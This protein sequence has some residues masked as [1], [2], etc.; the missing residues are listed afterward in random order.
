MDHD[1]THE[2][3]AWQHIR[4]IRRDKG[5]DD[6][7]VPAAIVRDLEAATRVLSDELY[8]KLTRFIM[9]LVQNADDNHYTSGVIPTMQLTY[10]NGFLRMDCNELGFSKANVEAICSI[11]QSSKPKSGAVQYVGEKGIGFKAVFKVADVVWV[12]SGDYSF[13]FDRREPLGMIAPI[14]EKPPGEK[15][16]GW[17]SFYIQLASSQ[18]VKELVA[19]LKILDPRLLL[20]LR[21]LKLIEIAV[22][23]PKPDRPIWK[24]SL[25]RGEKDVSLDGLRAVQLTQDSRPIRYIITRH[26]IHGLKPEPKRPGIFISEAMLA[27]PVDSEQQP[28]TSF[29]HVFAF[30]PIHDYGFNFLIQGDFLLIANREDIDGSSNWNCTIRDQLVDAFVSCVRSFNSK[31]FIRHTWPRYLPQQAKSSGLNFFSPFRSALLDRLSQDDILQNWNG[32]WAVSSSLKHVPCRFRDDSGLP[33]TLTEQ[34]AKIYLS[35]KYADVDIELLKR[36]GVAEM[37]PAGFLADLTQLLKTSQSAFQ[38]RPR[39][40]HSRLAAVLSDLP[41]DL[42]PAVRDLAIIP[43]RDGRWT[44]VTGNTV[45]FPND[46]AGWQAPG[47]LDL[48]VAHSDVVQDNA[49]HHLCRQLG[50]KPLNMSQLAD[51]IVEVHR[52]VHFDGT[53]ISTGDLISQVHFL[54]CTGWRNCD[55]DKVRLWAATEQNQRARSDVLYL[56][57]PGLSHSAAQF[58]ANSRQTHQFL[59]PN[60]LTAEPKDPKDW[61]AWLRRNLQLSNLPRLVQ[62]K[63]ATQ[64]VL[65][66]DFSFIMK[67]SPAL[68][69]LFLLCDHWQLVYGPWLVDTLGHKDAK[70]ISDVKRQLS[71]LQ[72]DCTHGRSVPL[73]QTFLPLP[74]IMSKQATVPL[75][76]IPDP[77][78]DRWQNLRHLGVGVVDNV[79]FYL[80]YLDGLSESEASLEDIVGA[81]E[82][83]QARSHEDEAAIETYFCDANRKILFTLPHSPDRYW[84]SLRQ[85]LWSGPPPLRRHFCLKNVYPSCQRLLKGLAGLRDVSLK[86]MVLEAMSFREEEDIY[87]IRSILHHLSSIIGSISFAGRDREYM[88][89][90]ESLGNSRIWPIRDPGC[91][92]GNVFTRLVTSQ[93]DEEWFI[94]DTGEYAEAFHGFLPSLCFAPEALGQIQHLL[95]ALSLDGRRLTHTAKNA[96]RVEGALQFSAPYTRELRSRS[97]FIRRLV[98]R[99]EANCAGLQPDNARQVLGQLQNIEVHTADMIFQRYAVKSGDDTVSSREQPADVALVPDDDGLKVYLRSG[100]LDIE[101][102]PEELISRIATYTGIDRRAD[103]KGLYLL[104]E[105]N[106]GTQNFLFCTL[107]T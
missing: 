97:E 101:Q 81:L 38:A 57:E 65:S 59:H 86:E 33:L 47:G 34:H 22:V 76:K 51:R 73:R 3:A 53:R 102:N 15:R 26:W 52:S 32:E 92:E 2:N 99:Q 1:D 29:Q 37:D 9:E 50:V 28:L 90:L 82:Q 98:P 39:Q 12:S 27:F 49:Q 20:F 94:S 72:V 68:D 105:T 6:G 71:E 30:L 106:L 104:Y 89:L 42:R 61:M 63:T 84:V 56:D 36:I 58:F 80:R 60:Y 66:E 83:I 85:C 23:S 69:V 67:N 62:Y 17:T 77:Q 45:F 107:L 54:Y 14:W 21:R 40:W 46:T 87:Y 91:T 75:L 25:G 16:A 70:S 103:N 43:L 55:V 100:Y 35:P 19:K 78:H 7:S 8:Q 10:A 93:P 11:G 74:T 41:E 95:S 79:S 5:L 96:P 18:N 24:T 48:L 88:R 44:R 13:K 64:F 4:D 31:P